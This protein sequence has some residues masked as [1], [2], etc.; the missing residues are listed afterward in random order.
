MCRSSTFALPLLL[1]SIGS[2]PVQSQHKPEVIERGKKATGLV[3]VKSSEGVTSGSAFCIDKSGLLVTNAHVIDEVAAGKGTVEIMLDTGLRTQRSVK[4]KVLRADDYLDLA[5]L[6][7]EPAARL[8]PLELGKDESLIETAPVLTFGFPLG[9][10]LWRVLPGTLPNMT[11]LVSRITALHRPKGRLEGVQFDNQI[12][13]GHSGGP[14]VD[15]A[16]RV[17][18]VAVA[19]I[20]GKSLNLAVPVGRLSEFLAAPGLHFNP[21]PC[22]TSTVFNP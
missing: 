7:V 5:L 4:A 11:V 20:P 22:R 3:E 21:P 12:N 8:T 17:I 1:L 2:A 10:E 14:V 15:E 6:K 19:T 16:G 13:H 18:G 9:R